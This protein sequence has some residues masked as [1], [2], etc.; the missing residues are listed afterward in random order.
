MLLWVST[1]FFKFVLGGDSCVDC[2]AAILL[3]VCFFCLLE[4]NGLDHCLLLGVPSLRG[5][6]LAQ[7]PAA[8]LLQAQQGVGRLALDSDPSLLRA[9]TNT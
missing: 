5:D 8:V 2:A 3:A 4:A 6:R 1:V 9:L 7:R